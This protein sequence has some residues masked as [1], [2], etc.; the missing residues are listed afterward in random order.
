MKWDF[1]TTS[2]S[3][4]LA[5]RDGSTIESRQALETL[6]QTYWYPLYAYV[7]LQGHDAEAALDL[8]QAYFTELLEKD[9]LKDVE[10]SLGRFRAFLKVSVKHFLSK[11]RD[12]ASTLKRGGQTR[13]VSLDVDDAETRYRFEPVDELTPEDIFERR[14]AFT[15]LEH[16]LGTLEQEFSAA[17]REEEFEKLKGFLV[18]EKPKLPQ[19]EVATAL[20]MS[21]N[22]VR[23]SVH[24]LR[25][26]FGKLLRERIA[27]TVA[28]PSEVDAEIRHLLGV[29]APF[30][31]GPA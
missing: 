25:Q 27:E 31:A 13:I 19:R 26:R 29:L 6:C 24:R 17:E 5:A 15:V 30:Q 22:A 20:G 16:V 7:R 4:V 2:W 12:K 28:D 3:Q 11:E 10:P 1:A 14:W 21:E 8:T 9:Y 23:A 18:G